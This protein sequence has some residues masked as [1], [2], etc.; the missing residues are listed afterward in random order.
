MIVREL[1][2]LLGFKVDSSGQKEYNK[3]IEETKGKQ[4]SLTAAILKANLIGKAAGAVLG[5]S[6]SFIKDS[7][8][9]ATAETERYRV[10][11]GTMMG[12]QEKANKIIRDLDYGEGIFEGSKISDFYGTAAAIGGLQSMV[13]FGMQAEEAGDI[14]TRLGDIAQGDGEAFSSMSQAMGKVFVAGKADSNALGI[15]ARSGFDVIGEVAKA[16]GKSREE[17]QKTGASYAQTKAALDALTSA[18]GKYEGMLAK[19][20]NTLGGIL[21][22]FASLK[23]ATAEAIG[24]GVTEELKGLLKFFLAAGKAGQEQFA[25]VFIRAI[26]EVINFIWDIIVAVQD[27]ENKIE[28]AGNI[29]EPFINFAKALYNSFQTA[30]QGIFPFVAQLALLLMAVGGTIAQ[31]LT[32]IIENLGPLFR[33]VFQF[34]AEAVSGAI[35]VVEMLGGPL[36]VI[37][38]FLGV[39]IKGLSGMID[40]LKPIA[41][42]I[43]AIATVI[44]IWTAAQWL[45][46]VAM[47]ANPIGLI[48]AAVVAAVA[49]I[50]GLIMV[51]VEHWDKIVGAVVNAGKA[52][53]NF[54]VSAGGKI[55]EFASNVGEK[56]GNAFDAIAG[57]AKEVA[58]KAVTAFAERFPNLY[59]LIINV[60]A[61]VKDVF[62]KIV[63]TVRPVVE[64]VVNVFKT[65]FSSVVDVVRSVIAGMVSVFKAVFTGIWNVVRTIFE[66]IWNTIKTV[67]DSVKAVVFSIINVFRTVFMSIWNVISGVFSTILGTI[68]DTF[69]GI[70]GIWRDGGGFFANLWESIKLIFTNVWKAILA[71]GQIVANAFMDI[72]ESVKNVFSTILQGIA[73]VFSSV[74]KGIVN[75]FSVYIKSIKAVFT[76]IV[77]AFAAVWAKVKA[78]VSKIGA[79]FVNLWKTCVNAL[80]SILSG[81]ATFFTNLWEGIVSVAKTVW[82]SLQ[83]WFGIFIETI[84]G[85]WLAITEW[86]ASLWDGIVGVAK[87]VWS[88]LTEWFTGLI[89]GIKAVWNGI[90]DFFSG[91]WEALMQGPQAAIEYIRTAF[92]SLFDGIQ[93]KLFGFIDKVKEGWD[94]VTGFFG[95]AV[96]GVV[97]FFTGG[98]P[99]IE[100]TAPTK[101]ND[102]ILTPEGQFQT[103]P[104]DYIMAMKNPGDLIDA[105]LRFLGQGLGGMPEPALAGAAGQGL[106]DAA[107]F[108]AAAAP[109]N[110]NN[111]TSSYS[112]SFQAPITVN[113]NAASMSPQE[114]E[115]AVKRGVVDAMKDVINSSRG[116]IPKPEVERY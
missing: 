66:S 71:I 73:N 20:S 47:M 101:V 33:S 53:G 64:A 94:K 38:T 9:G 35:P 29:F 100:K 7:V 4:Q 11:L 97:N 102:M 40:F 44:G 6:F 52:V 82:T 49:L 98:D 46:N 90:T 18:G 42:L 74:W 69:D 59:A 21:K 61:K 25:N 55:K 62:W 48:V 23:A 57:K 39:I 70:I 16:T 108:Q 88:G 28:D 93:Q 37:G 60:I 30:L 109:S 106:M 63:E 58:G 77:G 65:V 79:A 80:K 36:S 12:D 8:I 107:M 68:M 87:S 24:F 116:N 81:L 75:T 85:I 56:V 43:G 67:F 78:G 89:D 5:A 115:A 113:V 111:T 17:I 96:T 114:A 32:P 54:F 104:D 50:V 3:G 105:V 15:F 2:T 31:F 34:L 110:Y 91:L 92:T 99:E 26:T 103:S 76:T 19:Q 22:Q 83:E 112:E 45:L 14:L 41:P 27:L 86:F 84:K 51:V 10:A 1:I 72:W 95:N 13:T